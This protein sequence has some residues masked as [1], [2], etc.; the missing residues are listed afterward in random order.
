MN[1]K[2]PYLFWVLLVIL[3]NFGF[4][5]A[6]PAKDVLVAVVLSFFFQFLK[7]NK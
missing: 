2:K 3:W 1:R 6:S 7:D 5:S 4:P